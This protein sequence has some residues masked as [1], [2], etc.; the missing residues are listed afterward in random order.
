MTTSRRNISFKNIN[1]VSEGEST[2]HNRKMNFINIYEILQ[3][4]LKMMGKHSILIINWKKISAIQFR[5]D[6][7]FADFGANL[8]QLSSPEKVLNPLRSSHESYPTMPSWV[9]GRE[10]PQTL[11][12]PP[13]LQPPPQDAAQ[14]GTVTLAQGIWERLDPLI[15]KGFLKLHT[16]ADFH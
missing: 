15:L 13:G 7:G 3:S 4:F 10:V 5:Q 8:I 6:W 9:N 1:F 14:I 11:K 12:R 2:R 16:P